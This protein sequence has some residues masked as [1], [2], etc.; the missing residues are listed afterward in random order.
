MATI[1]G[2][3]LSRGP[4]NDSN[5]PHGGERGLSAVRISIIVLVVV[6]ILVGVSV[7]LYLNHRNSELKSS[8]VTDVRNAV[9]VMEASIA[10]NN[11]TFEGL[12]IYGQKSG[13]IT[14]SDGRVI[15]VSDGNNIRITDSSDGSDYSIVGWN[16]RVT[17]DHRGDEV[18][19]GSSDENV[20]VDNSSTGTGEFDAAPSV[21]KGSLSLCAGFG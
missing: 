5:S 11:G 21:K 2:A 19:A 16:S 18:V 13:K 3:G 20:Y 17:S 6:G 9:L 1:G 15:T 12:N 7:P 4:M 10:A 8:V 14:V